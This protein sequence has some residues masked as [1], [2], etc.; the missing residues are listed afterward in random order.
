MAV[1]QYIGARYVPK[2]Y[3]NSDGTE[4]WR[5]GVEYEPLTIVTYN[6]NSYTSKKPV[7]SNIGN[8]SDN[9]AYWVSTGNYNQQVEA[10]RQEVQE[11]KTEVDAL[12]DSVNETLT[13]YKNRSQSL[14]YRRFVFI[15]DSYAEGYSPEGVF[16]GWPV[17]TAEYLR[18]SA[19]Q[20]SVWYR[21]GSGF[22][23]NTQGRDFLGLLNDSTVD[24][25]ESVTDVVVAGGYNDNTKSENDIKSAI[26]LFCNT[27]R[28]KYP[29]AKIWIGELGWSRLPDKL[30]PLS[31]TIRSYI[32]GAEAAGAV[33]MSNVHYSLHDVF[34]MLVTD[35]VHPNQNGH[36]ALARSI[37]NCLLGLSADVYMP[38]TSCAFSNNV[39]TA[40]NLSQISC[41]MYNGTMTVSSATQ[42]SLSF[43]N[44]VDFGAA[45]GAAL[46][47]LATISGGL[48]IGCNYNNFAIPVSCVVRIGA[49]TYKQVSACLIIKSGHLYITF[50]KVNAG[51]TGWETLNN[52]QYLIIDRFSAS[53]DSL[54]C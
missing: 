51:E 40:D 18:L 28:S 27:C 13:N 2:F 6:G 31:R 43:E 19:N 35:G 38:F 41:M 47:D 24:D 15:G 5:A 3:E 1:T 9:T 22:V 23:E 20:Y 26:L 21:G 33:Y 50:M 37:A 52:V 48:V 39:A 17:R 25:P 12:E 14:A 32:Q 49:S 54:M 16:V 8:P 36:N 34:G 11:Y 44:G 42:L 30:Y 46:H 29:N 4:E 7:P 53:F 10:Y 45:T